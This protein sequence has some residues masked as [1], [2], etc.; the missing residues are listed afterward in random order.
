MA[1]EQ[2]FD[3]V[4]KA[5]AS[6]P[7]IP[8][9]R[10]IF[11]T[12]RV[13]K[14]PE[15]EKALQSLA[16]IDTQGVKTHFVLLATSVVNEPDTQ[17]NSEKINYN[18][19][20]QKQLQEWIG[21]EVLCKT[22]MMNAATA[23]LD[24]DFE[25]KLRTLMK[26]LSRKLLKSNAELHKKVLLTLSASLQ[27]G[28]KVDS[29]AIEAPTLAIV[30]EVIAT[31]HPPTTQKKS[32]TPAP[33]VVN[34]V[35]IGEYVKLAGEMDA[36]KLA[37]R[38]WRESLELVALSRAEVASLIP[39]FVNGPSSIL[40]PGSMRYHVADESLLKAKDRDNKRAFWELAKQLGKEGLIARCSCD[41]AQLKASGRKAIIY[42]N[43]FYLIYWNEIVK[44]LVA[45]PLKSESE[46]VPYVASDSDYQDYPRDNSLE[47]TTP[48]QKLEVE[49]ALESIPPYDNHNN[50]KSGL[51]EHL[52]ALVWSSARPPLMDKLIIDD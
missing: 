44:T 43:R 45:V 26:T 32:N 30:P 7:L 34:T 25:A 38:E 6:L 5:K 10:L 23:R 9:W 2:V 8:R 39:L 24:A 22:E 18:L 49:L 36:A 31:S 42:L 51:S 19:M 48:L 41:L 14:I 20:D 12:S 15:N 21:M 28:I 52:D 35:Q 37:A 1:Y 3:A 27:I 50:L 40:T 29:F 4:K 16:Y 46:I 11:L 47:D 13:P 33:V 17:S